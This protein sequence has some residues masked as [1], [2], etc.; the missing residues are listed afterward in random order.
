MRTDFSIDEA[1]ASHSPVKILD[2]LLVTRLIVTAAELKV[3]HAP[4]S[5]EESIPSEPRLMLVRRGAAEYR[6][7]DFTCRLGPGQ[8]IFMP[9]WVR[10]TW[11]VAA[12]PG[13][14]SLAWC[15]FS[16]TGSL[17]SDWTTPILGKVPDLDLESA[18]FQRMARL[19]AQK[20]QGAA[21][22]AEGE[23]KAVL[24]RFFAHAPVHG[25][26]RTKALSCGEHG[27][28]QALQ[29][30]RTHF[31]E[32]K[33]LRDLAKVA[34][35]H[36]K[37]FRVLFRKHTGLTP[38][39]YLI[40]LRMRAARYYQH[41]SSLRVKEVASAVGYDDP[42]Y[43]SRLYRKYWGHAPTDDRRTIQPEAGGSS[44]GALSVNKKVGAARDPRPVVSKVI[45]QKGKHVRS[46]IRKLRK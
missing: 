36:P 41:E 17:L 42:F 6:I 32:P 25:I 8:M 20:N 12:K 3:R 30:L 19:M 44:F 2:Q 7:D 1:L 33:V 22:E 45:L 15:R 31:P 18:S 29:Y 39:S 4:Y 46:E 13:L 27:I 9:A 16:S 28:E 5:L 37:Y 38:S 24:A 21:L 11:T 26:T 35:L 10:R 40:Q 34:G 43:F 14:T 23:L